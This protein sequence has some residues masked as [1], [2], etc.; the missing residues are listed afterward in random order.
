MDRKRTV[1]RGYDAIAEEYLAERSAGDRERELVEEFAAA[2]PA[3][4][5]VLDA[6]CGAGVPATAALLAA[7]HRV[8]GL[9]ASREQL[10]LAGER[11]PAAAR[12][13][14]DLAGLPF[15]E[16]AFDGLVAYHSII[17]VP[18]EEHGRVLGEFARVLR[19]GGRLLVTTG[20]EPWEGTNP[21][22]LDAGAEMVWS[23][24][25]RERSLELLTETGFDVE[26]EAVVGDEMGGGEWLFVRARLGESDST[27]DDPG[28]SEADRR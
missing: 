3:G 23:F 11:V 27:R 25:G 22:W 10:R 1:R 21:D 6:G 19:P 24:H 15:R 28:A 2:L 8:V 17:H 14:G 13:Q 5:R 4:A 16:E 7:G 18:R 12:V 9:D 26:D 20:V